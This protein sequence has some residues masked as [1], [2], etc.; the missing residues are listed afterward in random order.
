MEKR[1]DSLRIIAQA[2]SSY[3]AEE[4]FISFNGGK[5]CTVLLDLIHQANLKDAKKI[6]C[7]YVRPLNPFSEIEEFVDRCRQHYGITIATVDG[8]IK[9]ALEQ[10]C[11]ADPQLKAC[12]MGSR[13][14][15]PYCERLASFQETD[16]GWPRLMRINPL[17]EWTCEDIW[18][19]IRE[20]N[21][22]YCALYDRGYT[23]IGDRTNTIPNPH[24]KVEA[25]SSGEEVTYLP[26]YTLQD[27]DK[28]ERA[29]RL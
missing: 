18:S 26:A 15:D 20:H 5:D 10:I 14:S 28:Y 23:S 29:G 7:I 19:Y 3:R 13:R 2:L 4:M 8:G 9:A 16:P 25:D 27:A 1:K 6:K 24:L 17:L 21:V 12:I 11:R 22:P